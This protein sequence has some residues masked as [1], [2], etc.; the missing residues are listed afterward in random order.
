M[1]PVPLI[2]LMSAGFSSG[3]QMNT[4]TQAFIRTSTMKINR[5]R[6]TFIQRRALADFLEKEYVSKQVNDKTFAEY[7]TTTLGFEVNGDHVSH[8]RNELEIPLY[9]PKGDPMTRLDRIEARLATI[10]QW[11]SHQSNSKSA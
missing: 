7:A 10:E 8:L 5:I 4:P 2:Q 1:S 6:L 3:K 11:I 9:K